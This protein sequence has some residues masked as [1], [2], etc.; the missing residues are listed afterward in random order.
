MQREEKDLW[1]CTQQER[2]MCSD[3]REQAIS[4]LCCL[5]LG[6]YDQASRVVMVGPKVYDEQ[7]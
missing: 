4:W 2:Q 7:L 1:V 6:T 5:T 3:V